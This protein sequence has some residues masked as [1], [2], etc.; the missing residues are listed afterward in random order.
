MIRSPMSPNQPRLFP[1]AEL[2]TTV[3]L[4]TA[5]FHFQFKTLAKLKLNPQAF[6]V[7]SL[8]P[9]ALLFPVF[10]LSESTQRER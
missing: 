6:F 5:T 8:L 10:H 1:S 4:S 7:K 3:R 9:H 2:D